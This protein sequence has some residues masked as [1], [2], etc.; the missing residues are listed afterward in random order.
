MENY[1]TSTAA[2]IN[3]EYLQSE[4]TTP[5][6]HQPQRR[7][8]L[9]YLLGLIVI[10]IAGGLFFIYSSLQAPKNFPVNQPIEIE[11]GSTVKEI[12]N[13]LH[14]EGVIKSPLVFYTL[15]ITQFDPKDLKASTYVFDKPLSASEIAGRLTLGDF[16]SNLVRLTH[17]EGESVRKLAE[18]IPDTLPDLDIDEFIRLA[19]PKEGYLFPDTY[20]VPPTFTAEQL[21]TVMEQ[22][23]DDAVAELENEINASHFTLEEIIIMASIIERE[24]NDQESMRMVSGIIQNRLAIDMALQVDASME[25]V[26]DKP[27]SE[28]NPED[29]RQDSPYNTYTNNG[30]TPTAIGNPGLEA[31][32]AV[33]EPT[34]SDYLYYI[35]GNDG[36]FYYARDFDAHRLNISRYLR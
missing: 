24:A 22:R 20:F 12:V 16:T 1:Q 5:S 17:R 14:A 19:T 6:P 35:T 3:S 23:F 28:L 25:Y 27:L 33:L 8:W 29:L 10:L 9:W 11:E 4:N 21:V 32:T 2:E 36:V 30:L 18:A 15:F 7:S 34:E 31:I 13:Q 26:L